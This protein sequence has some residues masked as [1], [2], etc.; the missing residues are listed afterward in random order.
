MTAI[1]DL[2][3]PAGT[4]GLAIEPWSIGEIYAVAANWA[5]ASAPV[6]T[7]GE[8]GW[9]RNGRQVAD[10]RHEPADALTDVLAAALLACGDDADEAV[11]LVADAIEINDVDADDED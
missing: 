4:Y 1:N 5:E 6:Y 2:T 8:D 7:Y 11:D 9:D 3:T 10:Y